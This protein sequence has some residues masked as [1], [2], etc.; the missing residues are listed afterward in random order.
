MDPRLERLRSQK[1]FIGTSSWKYEG[2]KDIVYCKPYRSQKQFNEECL[3]EYAEHFTAV[4]VDHTYYAWPSP[5]LIKRYANQTPKEFKFCL[6]A[7]ERATVFKYPNLKRYGKE[8][9]KLNDS[10]LEP[11]AFEDNFL[12]PLEPYSTRLGPILI[13]FSQFYPGMIDSGREFVEKLDAF[14]E[15]VAR[16]KAFSFAVE[17][18]NRNWL[19]QPYLEMLKRHGVGHVFNSWT[20][21][22]E[23]GAQLEALA[24]LKLARFAARLLLKPG[25]QYAQAVE[26]FSPYNELKQVHADIRSQA[27]SL[28][29]RAVSLG[30]PAYVFVNNRFEGCAP[31]TIAAILDELQ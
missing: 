13:E 10:F 2:W 3:A 31:L 14:L 16:H 27:A 24:D 30:I 29:K 6:K 5:H 18:R 7:T 17:I 8:A 20:R 23:I 1:V 4:G 28:I 11:G 26:A 15:K 12:I 9:G 22:P 21:M 25:T 19:K